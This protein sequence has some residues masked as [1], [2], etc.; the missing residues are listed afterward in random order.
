MGHYIV[1]N[2][3]LSLKLVIIQRFCSSVLRLYKLDNLLISVLKYRTH[4]RVGRDVKQIR[5]RGYLRIKPATG[6]K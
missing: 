1:I 3:F 2:Y 5:T 6:R 4:I